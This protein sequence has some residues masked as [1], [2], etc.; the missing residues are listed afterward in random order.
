[1]WPS[2]PRWPPAASASYLATNRSRKR[3]SDAGPNCAPYAANAGSA[4]ACS[5]APVSY[6]HLTLP[7]IYS[8]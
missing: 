3:S 6:T 4:R 1:M 5:A 7:T 2:S 8:V